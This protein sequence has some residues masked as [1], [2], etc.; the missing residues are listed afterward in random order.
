V[1]LSP[2]LRE[3]ETDTLTG[4]SPGLRHY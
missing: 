2:A 4:R 3:I 1:V